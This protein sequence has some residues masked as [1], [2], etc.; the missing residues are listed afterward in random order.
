MIKNKLIKFEKLKNFTKK[1]LYKV[2]LDNFSNN[3]VTDGLCEASLRGVDS[4]GIRLLPF[5]IK[6]AKNLRKNPKPKYTFKK[7]YPAFGVLNADNA[8]G[9]A[10][11]NKA[12]SYAMKMSDKYGIGAVSVINSTHP[13]ALASIALKAAKKN[14]ICWAF[15]HADSLLLSYG[16]KRPFFGTNPICVAVPRKNEEPY[17]LDMST[18]NYSWNKLIGHRE[19]NIKLK[20]N[21]AANKEGKETLNPHL[22]KSLFPL[23]GYKGYGLASLIE[24]LCGIYTGMNFAREIPPMFTSDIKKKRKLGQF[25][26]IM[27]TDACISQNLFF[28]RMSTLKKQI[29]KEPNKKNHKILLPNDKEILTAKKRF[30]FGIP[31]DN[32]TFSDLMKLSKN[33]SINFF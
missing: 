9:L 26:F 32:K 33:Y 29:K 6:S 28:K 12:V 13:G 22:A 24:I 1:I 17:C 30:K 5:Y 10:A 4:H 2:G 31:L 16:G 25:Y 18:S 8:F 20:K 3:S 27:K 7:K 11:G 19:N 15:T 14:Y 21:I 23:G